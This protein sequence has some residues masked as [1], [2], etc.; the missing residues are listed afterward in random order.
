MWKRQTA[1]PPLA[2][3][4]PFTLPRMSMARAALLCTRHMGMPQGI[5]I[6]S[7]SFW[8]NWIH[9]LVQTAAGKGRRG[10][11][12]GGCLW[13]GNGVTGGGVRGLPFHYM[14]LSIFRSFVMSTVFFFFSFK[15]KKLL[16]SKLKEKE[17]SVGI[18]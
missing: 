2:R 13:E 9:G 1:V 5:S 3:V 10:G 17:N 11:S 8:G 7:R 18:Q 15:K 4:P 6:A 14:I 12:N 16:E